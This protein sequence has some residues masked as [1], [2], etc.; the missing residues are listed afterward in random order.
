MVT[1]GGYQGKAETICEIAATF[2]DPWLELHE[3]L[4]PDAVAGA[5]DLHIPI[6]YVQTPVTAKPKSTCKTILNFYAAPLNPRMGWRVR[7]ERRLSTAL[8]AA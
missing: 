4:N 7:L 1:G 5:R 2:E 6:A 8:S 3:H